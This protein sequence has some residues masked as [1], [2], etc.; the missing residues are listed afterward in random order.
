M[1]ILASILTSMMVL[2]AFGRG[3]KFPSHPT[4][5]AKSPD[6]N[7]WVVWEAPGGNAPES[8]H[9]LLLRNKAATVELRRFDR[10]CDVLWSPDS[11]HIALTDWLGSN[12]SDVLIYSPEHPKT[13]TSLSSVF[14]SNAIPE[15]ELRGHCYFE[16]TKWLDEHRL[17]VRVF[18]HTDEVQ[19]H[20]F[21]HKY[22]FDVQAGRFEAAHRTLPNPPH[23]ANS[24]LGGQGKSRSWEMAAVADAGC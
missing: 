22:V 15:V 13:A 19:A 8:G 1:K 11:A 24:R 7:W 18:G 23:S 4:V 6:S 2:S 14:P 12:L 21:Q 3:V 9:Q 20:S 5:K 17:S 16:A 10:S